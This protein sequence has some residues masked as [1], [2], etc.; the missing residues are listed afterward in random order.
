MLEEDNMDAAFEVHKLNDV[1]ISKAGEIAFKFD[2]LL[3]ELSIFCLPGRELDLVKINL[4]EA[5]FFAKKAMAI[6]PE[7]T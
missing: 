3:S 1:G 2:K 4:E 6:N 5:C 7:N